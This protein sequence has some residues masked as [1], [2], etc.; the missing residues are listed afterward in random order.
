MA[1]FLKNV[2]STFF[3][4]QKPSLVVTKFPLRGIKGCCHNNIIHKILFSYA[5]IF[6]LELLPTLLGHTT[7]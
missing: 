4:V 5:F 3:F 1:Q 6:A 2:T 7:G